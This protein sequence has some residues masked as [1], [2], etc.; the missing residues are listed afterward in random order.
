M[1]RPTSRSSNQKPP[2]KNQPRGSRTLGA[3]LPAFR[4][5]PVFRQ[6][7]EFQGSSS[8]GS[9]VSLAN[10]RNL[11]FIPTNST[12][13]GV[14]IFDA[15]RIVLLELWSN[16]SSATTSYNDLSLE[17]QG[18][19]TPGVITKSSGT[20][21]DAAHIR[22]VP[23]KNSFASFWKSQNDTGNVFTVT[24]PNQCNLRVTLEFTV[25]N[26]GGNAIGGTAL[27]QGT[28]YF[29]N[30]NSDFAS[31]SVVASGTLWS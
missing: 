7:F 9:N 27:T 18:S 31:T 20:A 10:L 29:N 14:S 17:W 21:F 28:V 25:C 26:G 4:Q 5:Y 24:A 12:T 2:R 11:I 23:P 16:Q 22:A 3:R 8:A 19:G 1:P 6:T 15:T 30:L 13:I